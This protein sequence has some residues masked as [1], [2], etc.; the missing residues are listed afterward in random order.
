MKLLSRRGFQ[1]LAFLIASTFALTFSI[2][3]SGQAK[4]SS[5]PV[6]QVSQASPWW[7]NAVIYEIYPRSFQDSNGDGVGDLNG[8]TSRLDYLKALGVDAVWLTPVYPSPQ[9]DFGYDISDYRAIDSQYGT[10]ADFDKLQQ[11]AKQRNIGL[12]MDLVL[13]HT[14]DK[15]PWF[16]ES[17]KSRTNPRANWYVWR[18]AKMVNGKPEPPNNWI[19]L[20]GGS[21]WQWDPARKQ[22]YYH[23]FYVQQP[24]LNWRNPQVRKA[25]YD[26]E[27]YWI[28][29]GVAGFRLDAI[30]ALFESPTF[31]DEPYVRD[32]NGKI[33]IS[34]Y[35]DKEVTS[36]KTD[37]LPGVNGVLKQLRQVADST[38]DPKWGHTAV[39]IGETY[40]DSIADLRKLYGLHNDELNLPMDMQV[41]FIN[42]LDVAE[43]RKN[44]NDAETKLDGYEPLFVFDNH[45]NAR[46]DRYS[47]GQHTQEIGRMLAAVL[48]ASRDTAMMYYGDEIGMKTTPPTRKQDVR[49][50][51]GIKGWPKEKGRD[52]ERT[53]M[54][55]SPVANAGFSK[56]GV[57]TWLPIPNTFITVNVEDEVRDP[58][59]MLNWYKQMI[60]LRKTNPAFRGR[61]VMLNT[62]NNRV[63]S[64]LRRAKGSP[65]VVVACNFTAQEQTIGFDL[66]AEGIHGSGVKTLLKSPGTSD[67]ASLKQVRLPAFGVYI[68]QVE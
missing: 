23:R 42:K 55:W 61:E 36:S 27:R 68:G 33:E 64:W 13:N 47:D 7:D 35:G 8:I 12:I 3:A 34:A 16:I 15:H 30:T 56:P 22:Y 59:S 26:V 49:D 29:R 9:V 54:Q 17:A 18:D 63:L 44:I 31:S 53:P 45:D 48:F 41:G 5:H 25:M 28:Q 62:D 39:L 66:S 46:W 14:S 21:S 50:P 37:N 19:S 10:L 24:D 67:P 40:V 38:S 43:F 20:F 32:K 11:Q 52:G 51:I 2:S 60:A 4:S 6:S 58:N 65:A 57:K 1:A